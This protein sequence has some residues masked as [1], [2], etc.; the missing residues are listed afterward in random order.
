MFESIH[1]RRERF[2]RDLASDMR[3]AADPN[4]PDSGGLKN[5]V[6]IPR[7]DS[8]GLESVRTWRRFVNVCGPRLLVLAMLNALASISA[9]SACEMAGDG[10]ISRQTTASV[11]FPALLVL[12]AISLGWEFR[13]KEQNFETV[14]SRLFC[15]ALVLTV[16]ARFI[17]WNAQ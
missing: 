2:W 14:F 7:H 16:V 10:A 17:V 8:A 12:G 3:S 5:S 15:G 6:R 1:D 11:V 9:A 4:S 13:K